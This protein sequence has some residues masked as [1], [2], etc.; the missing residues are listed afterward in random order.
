MIGGAIFEFSAGAAEIA[1]VGDRESDIASS[2]SALQVDAD[3]VL[4]P[5][6]RT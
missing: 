6:A 3:A 2:C 1:L 5:P 4:K